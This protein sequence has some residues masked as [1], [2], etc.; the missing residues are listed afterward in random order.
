MSGYFHPPPPRGCQG[1]PFDG[2]W[3]KG[4]GYFDFR[5]HEHCRAVGELGF[6]VLFTLRCTVNP[7][8]FGCSHRCEIRQLR[9]RKS[10]YAKQLISVH[11]DTTSSSRNKRLFIEIESMATKQATTRRVAFYARCSTGGQTTENQLRDLREV[12]TRMD[13]TVVAE[14]IDHGVSGSKGRDKRPQFDAL[15]KGAVRR[16]FDV[17]AAWSVDRLSRSLQHLIEFLGVAHAKGVDIYLHRQCL[18]TATPSGKA[19]FQLL[20][21]FSEFERALIQERV[22]AGLARAV[23]AGTRL[24]RPRVSKEVESKIIAARRSGKGI[25]AVAAEV[26]VGTSVVQR[27]AAECALSHAGERKA[28]RSR[29]RSP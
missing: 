23:A 15:C 17:I 8:H 18:D 19:L 6:E 5:C 29:S 4:W 12:A 20:G 11:H 22:R 25:R 10:R 3:Q 7:K 27:V 16:E 14:F 1:G 24:G 2:R 9:S 13:W 26:G 28:I 21:V